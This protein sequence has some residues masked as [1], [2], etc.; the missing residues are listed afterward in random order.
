[1]PLEGYVPLPLEFDVEAEDCYAITLG[2]DQVSMLTHTRS[3]KPLGKIEVT[4]C[5]HQA[6][7]SLYVWPDVW[8]GDLQV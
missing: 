4:I 8:S 1:M 6:D 3:Y 5:S 2:D 7:S